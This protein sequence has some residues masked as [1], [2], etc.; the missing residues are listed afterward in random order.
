[1][2]SKTVPMLLIVLALGLPAGAFS[3]E[4]ETADGPAPGE[5][6]EV[7]EAEIEA[8]VDAYVALNEV[9]EE[10]NRQLTEAEDQDTARELQLE[11]N[12]A[13]VDAIEET[14]MSPEEYQQ[15]A[16]AVNA[17][18]EVRDRVSQLLDERE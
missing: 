13:M 8:F 1:M 5:I 11:A 6:P 10:Y 7:S 4:P 14:G 15:V 9:R 17:D 2:W 18:P 3:G 12:E 16:T